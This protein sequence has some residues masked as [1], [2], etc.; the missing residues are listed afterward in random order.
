MPMVIFKVISGMLKLFLH[1]E[2]A[3][4]AGPDI[5]KA[6]DPVLV[7]IRGT[8]NL[9]EFVAEQVSHPDMQAGCFLRFGKLLCYFKMNAKPDRKPMQSFYNRNGTT[10]T[11]VLC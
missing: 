7:F 9:L 5:E 11:W 2:S 6:L 1:Y 3:H 8:T 4:K 10:K